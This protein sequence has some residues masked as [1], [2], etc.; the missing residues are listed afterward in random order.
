MALSCKEK[1][2]SEDYVDWVVDF[3]LDEIFSS[4]KEELDYC[5]QEISEGFGIISINR[6]QM[7][8]E[9]LLSLDY[10]YFPDLL[11][12]QQDEAEEEVISGNMIRS[13]PV[14]SQGELFDPSPLVASGIT[15]V[16]GA[17]LYLTGRGVILAFA[18]TG[19]NYENEV[20]RKEDG[21]SRILAIWD[22]TIQEGAPPEG[23]YIGTE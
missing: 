3:P 20:F 22:Q 9:S 7:P 12:I 18:D 17:P 10:H 11:G 1:I 2:L 6:N 14:I 4:Y 19:I 15:Q 13:E 21:S 16:Q 5:Y 8:D 23:F